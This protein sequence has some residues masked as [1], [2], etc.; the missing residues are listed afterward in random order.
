MSSLVSL[1]VHL[2]SHN[3]TTTTIDRLL[4]HIYTSQPLSSPTSFKAT[5]LIQSPP[6]TL[7]PRVLISYLL[8]YLSGEINASGS[9]HLI[10]LEEKDNVVVVAVRP[11]TGDAMYFILRDDPPNRRLAEDSDV[12]KKPRRRKNAGDFTGP[13]FCRNENTLDFAIELTGVDEG[14]F[15]QKKLR[16]RLYRWW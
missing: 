8:L 12:G 15:V 14:R 5:P 16:R 6:S 3:H 9:P 7:H 13:L 4:L 2:F 1:I 10:L 11:N